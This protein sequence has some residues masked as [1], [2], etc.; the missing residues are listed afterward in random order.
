MDVRSRH[1]RTSIDEKWISATG[2]AGVDVFAGNAW[3]QIVLFSALTLGV[4]NPRTK[5]MLQLS[6]ASYLF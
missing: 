5:L 6:T 1:S 2:S 3:P 4:L